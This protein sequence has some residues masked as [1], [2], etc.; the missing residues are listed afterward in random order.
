MFA[1][2]Q[3]DPFIR[4]SGGVSV[5]L[6][7]AVVAGVAA[8]SCLM[9]AMRTGDV[10][11]VMPFR[12]TRLL[13]GITLGVVL[14]GETLTVSML[15]GSGLIVVSDLFILSRGARASVQ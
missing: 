11:A 5:Y 15:L 4:P 10:S 9:K 12:Y 1:A 2:W 6:L 14:F 7:G 8:Y 3:A 13:F